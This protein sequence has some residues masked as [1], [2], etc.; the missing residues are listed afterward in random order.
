VT[1]ESNVYVGIDVSKARLDVCVLP[2][3]ESWSI[4]HNSVEIDRLVEKL[5]ALTPK[6]IVVEATG[7]LQRPLVAA[8]AVAK[9]EVAVV[10]PRQVRDFA[11][12]TGTLA[13]TDRLDAALLARFG[14]AVKPDPRPV[15][16]EHLQELDEL[17]RRR[18]EL[19][20]MITAESH[21]LATAQSRPLKQ[22]LQEHIS[23][24]NRRLKN[25]DGDLDGALKNSA[26]WWR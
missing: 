23:W 2:A 8:L 12:A 22:D 19:V 10:N 3:R 25:L 18:R 11:R 20:D 7:G 4:P 26:A 21:R 14:E 15:A 5:R 9:V 1:T 13:K 17:V 16:D 24:L 6:L